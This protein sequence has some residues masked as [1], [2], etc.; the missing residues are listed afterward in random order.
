MHGSPEAKYHRA[1]HLYNLAEYGTDPVVPGTEVSNWT[2]AHAAAEEAMWEYVASRSTNARPMAYLILGELARKGNNHCG[3]IDLYA[4]SLKRSRGQ[5]PAYWP[6]R[7]ILHHGGVNMAYA[8]LRCGDG[9]TN[10]VG[11]AQATVDMMMADRSL[12]TNE[13]VITCAAY[14]Y[15]RLGN[16]AYNATDYVE[17]L[18]WYEKASKLLPEWPDFACD[19][20]ASCLRLS[21]VYRAQ[22]EGRRGQ[23]AAARGLELL[24]R[25]QYTRFKEGRIED[26]REAL[27]KQL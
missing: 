6:T 9:N 12:R 27:R 11:L 16:D 5:S 3:A 22:G 19:M 7:Y 18:A 23:D 15:K 8:C 21:E 17:A 1:V 2:E 25:K 24:S 4:E 10:N 13:D 14:V 20:A 26:L